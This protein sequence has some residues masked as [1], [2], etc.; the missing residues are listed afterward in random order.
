VLIVSQAVTDVTYSGI[1]ALGAPIQLEKVSTR[2]ESQVLLGII[3]IRYQLLAYFTKLGALKARSPPL[4]EWGRL[5]SPYW[6]KK[7]F[8]L[9]GSTMAVNLPSV[10]LKLDSLVTLWVLSVR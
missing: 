10:N 6:R 9:R 2:L 1:A 3:Y 8:M 5:D 7:V 4:Q